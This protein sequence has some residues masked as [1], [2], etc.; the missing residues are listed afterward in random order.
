MYIYLILKN[1]NT[2][3]NYNNYVPSVTLRVTPWVVQYVPT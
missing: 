1:K 2:A 3:R